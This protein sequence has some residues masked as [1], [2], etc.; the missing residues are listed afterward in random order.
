MIKKI[1]FTLLIMLVSSNISFAKSVDEVDGK[2][3]NKIDEK[4][5]D[6]AK[7][8]PHFDLPKKDAKEQCEE[9]ERVTKECQDE[10]KLSENES[11]YSIA[12][13]SPIYINGSLLK[14]CGN[15]FLISS[16]DLPDTCT[17]MLIINNRGRYVGIKKR[18]QKWKDIEYFYIDRNG[19]IGMIYDEKEKHKKDLTVLKTRDCHI[20]SFFNN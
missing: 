4:N 5:I 13:D 6:E 1:F 10:I 9:V 15:I 8:E 14:K 18:C 16:L 2:N 11:N 17:S 3:N 20:I 7:S 12:S 19:Y